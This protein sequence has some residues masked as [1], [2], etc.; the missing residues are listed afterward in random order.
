MPRKE[1]MWYRVLGVDYDTPWEEIEAAYRRLAKENHPDLNPDDSC[2]TERMIEINFAWSTAKERRGPVAASSTESPQPIVGET[3]RKSLYIDLDA[4]YRGGEHFVKVKRRQVPVNVPPGVNSGYTLQKD[5]FGEAGTHG[6]KPGD[7][8]VEVFIKEDKNFRRDGNNL[9]VG[10]YVTW[11]EAQSGEKVTVPTFAQ[12]KRR[13]KDKALTWQ[14]PKGAKTGEIIRF[15][16]YGM[17]LLGS[18]GRFGDLLAHLIVGEAPATQPTQKKSA[19]ASKPDRPPKQS[20]REEKYWK[21][22]RRKQVRKRVFLFLVILFSTFMFTQYDW[23]AFV[24]TAVRFFAFLNSP[25]NTATASTTPTATSTYTATASSTPTATSTYT[26]TASATPTTTST[27]TATATLQARQL[28]GNPTPDTSAELYIREFRDG[29]S[30]NVRACAGTRTCQV[31]GGIQ[32]GKP[33]LGAR[34]VVGELY[35]GIDVWIRFIF[36]DRAGFVHSSLVTN[37]EPVITKQDSS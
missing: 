27:K 1:R 20:R 4:A 14:L 5:G 22:H 31:I 12:A 6:G 30:V 35:N 9:H 26:A 10:V 15:Q 18:E 32:S 13:G 11:Q 8:I 37:S 24:P 19:Q 16:G 33:L 21:E 29:A 23:I 28:D 34:Q 7:L 2:A 36:G 25:T 3:I 17:P